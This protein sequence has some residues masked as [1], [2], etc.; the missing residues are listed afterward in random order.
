MSYI[1]PTSPRPALARRSIG[2]R[3]SRGRCGASVGWEGA[4]PPSPSSEVRR[5]GPWFYVSGERDP[6]ATRHST[7]DIPVRVRFVWFRVVAEID[8]P[9]S[10]IRGAMSHLRVL[11][12]NRKQSCN[13][14]RFRYTLCFSG[15][16][17]L[18]SP[19]NTKIR[20]PNEELP[21]RHCCNLSH[22]D[23]VH[24]LSGRRCAG[25]L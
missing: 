10:V 25:H 9:S 13:S 20:S 8:G 17:L 1:C 22:H 15:N 16:H 12:R 6:L 23:I 3:P 5:F 18:G 4:A 7:T 14:P 19:G 21:S 24:L 11:L 2:L